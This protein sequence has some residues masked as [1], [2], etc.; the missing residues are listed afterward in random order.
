M[1]RSKLKGYAALLLVFVLGVLL[2]GAGS[3]AITQRG[4]AQ[5][6]KDPSAMF[7]RRRLGALSRRLHLDDAQEDKVRAILHKYAEQRR[8]LNRDMVDRCGAP[9]REQKTKMDAEIR[10]L[11]SPEQQTRY[12]K[13]I[14]DADARGPRGGLGDPMQ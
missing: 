5:I 8:D 3:R 1:D 4:I 7:E 14:R 10:A 6:F 13:L 12:D 2:G 11:L 9:L